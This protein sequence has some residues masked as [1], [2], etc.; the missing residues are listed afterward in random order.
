MMTIARPV[1][2]AVETNSVTTARAT[3][4]RRGAPDRWGKRFF[5]AAFVLLV[6][7]PGIQQI[8]RIFPVHPLT[9]KRA[10]ALMPGPDAASVFTGG[11]MSDFDRYY[12]DRSGFRDPLIR[13]N[14]Q[15]HLSVFHVTP[16]P[17]VILGKHHWYF[18]NETLRDYVNEWWPR[19]KSEQEWLVPR[20]VAL[21]DGLAKRGVRFVFVIIP[22]KNTIYP[23]YMP[24]R[25][26]RRP[27]IRLCDRLAARLRKQ[28]VSVL[29]L[30]EALRRHKHEA[31]LYEERGTH[32]NPLGAC[33]GSIAILNE[34]GK[35]YG[36]RYPDV[37]DLPHGMGP[38]QGDLTG[39]VEG[40]RGCVDSTPYPALRPAP[41]ADARLP[42]TLW[43]GDSFTIAMKPYLQPQF[44]SFTFININRGPM[45]ATLMPR[46]AE[47]RIVVLGLVER[48]LRNVIPHYA[49]P[50][51]S[52][53][54]DGGSVNRRLLFAAPRAQPEALRRR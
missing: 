32:W 30:E 45:E 5:V 12:N 31:L 33:Y 29:C 9:E 50:L 38:A 48:N 20:I 34:L 51:Q 36:I 4:A 14:N 28:G 54:A 35:P 40:V 23:E 15:I 21:R 11:F 2:P 22:N 26:R 18:Y 49:L 17:R 13:L 43:Y 44:T 27:G 16:N 7:V 47:T 1:E 46:L 53:E 41:L 3:S 25:Y 42:A 19:T 8:T 37:R 24:D 6:G 39:M 10:K 52:T